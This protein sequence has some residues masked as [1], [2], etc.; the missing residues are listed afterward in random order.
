MDLKFT[1][2][3][4]TN[5]PLV[6][7]LV[8]TSN[9]A[10]GDTVVEIG[11]GKGAITNYLVEKVGSAGKVLVV[12]LD[13]QL[14]KQLREKF[15]IAEILQQDVRDFEWPN[16]YFKVFSNIPFNITSDIFN[17]LLNPELEL[18]TAYLIVQEEAALMYGGR[19]IG[20][21]VETLKSL[22]CA[23]FYDFTVVH[24][25]VESDFSP[26]PGVDVVCLKVKRKTLPLV[27]LE[28]FEKYYDF[29]AF[30]ISSPYGRGNWEKLFT[31]KQLQYMSKLYKLKFGVGMSGQPQDAV[32]GSFLSFLEKVS[33]LNK[34]KV[35]GAFSTLQYQQ[36]KLSKIN[37]TRATGY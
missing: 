30:V 6:K 17:S 35:D 19:A 18:D 15:N 23:P 10:K 13:A 1:Q 29:L 25:F 12:E 16:K 24:K 34:K 2:N 28:R 36:M 3:F 33:E 4:L 14:A 22:L 11:G 8:E 20:A 5:E 9:I 27:S 21:S 26:R 37:R 31:S 32:I 7:R